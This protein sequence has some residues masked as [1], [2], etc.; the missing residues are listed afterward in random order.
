MPSN[1][2]DW[3]QIKSALI[4][5]AE[6]L[7]VEFSAFYLGHLLSEFAKS[8]DPAARRKFLDQLHLI[9]DRAPEILSHNLWISKKLHALSEKSSLSALLS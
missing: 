8:L 9:K 5:F 1:K 7:P 6:S 4:E 2:Y 3:G